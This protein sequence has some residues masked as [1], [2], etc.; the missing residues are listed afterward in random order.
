MSA[1]LIGP[2]FIN[3]RSIEIDNERGDIGEVRGRKTA[4]QFYA[5]ARVFIKYDGCFFSTTPPGTM[6]SRIGKIDRI[7]TRLAIASLDL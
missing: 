3:A 2:S 4:T 7:A 1:R 6:L 5:G